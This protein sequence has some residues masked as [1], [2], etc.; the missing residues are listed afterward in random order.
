MTAIAA[1]RTLPPFRRPPPPRNNAAPE[2]APGAR[3]RL[4]PVSRALALLAAGLA[5]VPVTT[6]TARAACTGSV[7]IIQCAS[8]AVVLGEGSPETGGTFWVP[9]QGDDLLGPGYPTPAG[10]GDDAGL[11]AGY[12]LD[13][14]AFSTFLTDLIG[15]GTTRCLLWDLS[16]YGSDGCPDG[17]TEPLAV[18]V[19]EGADR[20]ALLQ[21]GPEVA[22]YDFDTIDNG[23]PSPF[24][25]EHNGVTTAPAVRVSSLSMVPP[26]FATI[27]VEPLAITSYDDQGG[28][29]AVP[30]TPRLV[31]ITG[32]VSGVVSEGGGAATVGVDA[33]SDLCW[34]LVDGAY[35]VRLGCYHVP[36]SPPQSVLDA[37]VSLVD[38]RAT[39]TWDVS[40]QVDVLWFNVVQRSA[41]G[42]WSQYVNAAPIAR[43]GDNDW[44]P[45][46]YR[47]EARWRDLRASKSSF[48]I[49]LVHEDGRR[50]YTR[51]IPRR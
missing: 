14:T 43:L 32:G 29:R 41:R 44:A 30:G 8:G 31:G 11:L 10:F 25:G 22:Y 47:H 17:T 19:R 35:T 3:R 12:P 16:S 50:E 7:P 28:T 40:A 21:V 15:D 23:G 36:L 45:A 46:S 4:R 5:F 20:F 33:D 49:E 51:V 24:G 13:P 1:A 2:L 37:T 6:S 27:G 39:F 48:A 34:H 18:V 26:Y 38:G 42:G 9:G